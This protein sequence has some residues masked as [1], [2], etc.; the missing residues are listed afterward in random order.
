MDKDNSTLPPPPEVSELMLQEF[1]DATLDLI[2]DDAT[3]EEIRS[4][5]LDVFDTH[6]SLLIN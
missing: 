1:L 6:G 3:P 2:E 5:L 4:L